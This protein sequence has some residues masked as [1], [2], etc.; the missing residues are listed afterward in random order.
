MSLPAARLAANA[1]LNVCLAAGAVVVISV[2]GVPE[3]AAIPANVDVS[4]L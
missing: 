1:S 2:E 4:T 3:A